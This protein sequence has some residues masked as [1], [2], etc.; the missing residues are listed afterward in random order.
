MKPRWL[1]GL[2]VLAVALATLAA[3]LGLSTYWYAHRR[4]TR[5]E[6]DLQQANATLR[7]TTKQ[8]EESRARAAQL[9]QRLAAII[10]DRDALSR[11]RNEADRQISALQQQLARLRESRYS[12]PAKAGE[13]R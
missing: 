1:F 11:R 8:L 13:R 6:T 3:S 4:I 2:V 9:E 5:M 10:V 12:T 7:E